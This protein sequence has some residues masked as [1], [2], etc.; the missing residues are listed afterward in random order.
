MPR[1]PEGGVVQTVLSASG[2]TAWALLAFA[3]ATEVAGTVSM[4][5]SLG[6][7]RLWPSVAVFVL[8]GISLALATLA[9]RSL[10]ITLTYAVW[11]ALG[12]AAI[13][14]I[15]ILWFREPVN[16]VKLIALVLIVVGVVALNLSDESG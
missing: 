1:A 3:I 15:G 7:T 6:F 9:Q 10:P 2:G 13:A 11:S 12:T 14:V 8:F 4:K 16:A 5:L